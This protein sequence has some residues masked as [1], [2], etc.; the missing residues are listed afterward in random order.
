MRRLEWQM[1]DRLWLA[2]RWRLTW[3]R[4]RRG[5]LRTLRLLLGQAHLGPTRPRSVTRAVVVDVVAAAEGA[6]VAGRAAC[7]SCS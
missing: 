1:P 7:C 3:G 6:A 5:G 2:G 4:L